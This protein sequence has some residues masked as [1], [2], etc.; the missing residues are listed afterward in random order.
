M[1]K[2]IVTISILILFSAIVA[3]LGVQFGDQ[4]EASVPGG[5][6][7]GLVGG[8]VILL[9]LFVTSY[10]SISKIEKNVLNKEGFK[11]LLEIHFGSVSHQLLHLVSEFILQME[12]NPKSF[13][14]DIFLMNCKRVLDNSRSKLSVYRTPQIPNIPEYLDQYL[15]HETLESHIKSALKIIE[16]ADE[17]SKKNRLAYQLIQSVQ[18]DLWRKIN[19]LKK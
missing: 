12:E 18:S 10:K 8:V 14:S 3:A 16:G 6:A 5:K 7:T 4:I 2:T 1:D 19:K 17:A 11:N 13:N 9:G 15:S